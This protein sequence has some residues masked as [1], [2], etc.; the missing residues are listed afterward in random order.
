MKVYYLF[1]LISLSITELAVSQTP[2]T[3]L[4][5]ISYID[6]LD[7]SV[8]DYAKERC[9]LD[10]YVPT[11]VD[12]FATVVWFH[13]G[14]MKFGNKFIPEQLQEK[15]IA[16][17]AVNYRLYPQVK[18]PAYI[19]DAAASIAYI[20]QH[21]EQY[22]GDPDQLFVS[23]HSAGGYLTTMIGLDTTYLAAHGMHPD[24]LAG[25]VPFSGHSITHMTVR[26]EMDIGP[27][28]VKVDQYA[29][30]AHLRKKTPPLL[31]ITGDRELELWGRYEETAYMW[32]MMRLMGN[33]QVE[34]MELDGFNHGNMY[35]PALYLLLEFMKEHGE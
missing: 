18:A 34:L 1:I 2:Y 25:L 27:L 23:G 13:G 22:G 6:T 19:E 29:P 9:R 7:E 11:A 12:S 5:N 30:L 10:L 24:Q 15:G 31:F 33:E 21:I 4:E 20:H 35:I 26:E 17:A 3:L 32:R 14:G 16:V 8:T 28:E